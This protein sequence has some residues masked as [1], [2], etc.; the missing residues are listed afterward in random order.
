MYEQLH[1]NRITALYCRLSRDDGFYE[2]SCSIV[3]QKSLLEKYANDQGFGNCQFFVDDGYTGTNYDRPDFKRLIGLV[4]SGDIGIIIVK[5]LSRLGREYLQTGY[6]TEVV[7]PSHDV[8]F[9]AI[10]DGI[11]STDGENEFAPFKNI[12]NEWYARDISRKIKTIRKISAERGEYVNGR[13]PYGYIRNPEHHNHLIPDWDTAPVVKRIFDMCVSG[14]GCIEIAGILK[15][16][17]IPRPSSYHLDKDGFNK[18]DQDDENRF[19]WCQRSVRDILMNPVYIGHLF[20]LRETTR[21][22]KDKR[23]VKIPEEQWIKCYN[24]HEAIVTEEVFRIAQSRVAVKRPRNPASA[25]NIYR[26]LMVCADCGS[27][28]HFI[29]RR[30]P[31]KGIGYYVCGFAKRMGAGCGC[32]QHYITIE[33]LEDM[34]LKDIN[35]I[36]NWI[37]EDRDGFLRYVEGLAAAESE[38]SR[39]ESKTELEAAIK[40]IDELNIIIKKLYEDQ[41]F[42]IISTERYKIL[43]SDYEAESTALDEKVRKLKETIIKSSSN[44]K[45]VASFINLICSYENIVEMDSDI[46]HNL[47]DKIF[48]HEKES[49]GDQIVMR[50]EVHYRFIGCIDDTLMIPKAKGRIKRA[51]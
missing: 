25:K 2:D 15:D 33:Q 8:R 23:P 47:I 32:S 16:E 1:D 31:H 7:F 18:A 21:S 34:L 46:A 49:Y 43:V 41:A 36:I 51:V 10:N 14:K 12:I 39:S 24:N 40:R 19:D 50:V 45:D 29:I 17:K 13:P 27:G 26:G 22:F 37:A 11:D 28:M 48:V 9:I 38:K 20:S 6:Y 35:R 30:P 5:D 3:S 44:R 42:G 4:D